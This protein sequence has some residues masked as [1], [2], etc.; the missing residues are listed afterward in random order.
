MASFSPGRGRIRRH[1]WISPFWTPPQGKMAAAR[2]MR[3][4]LS[5]LISE[6]S[7]KQK[8]YVQYVKHRK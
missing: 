1:D 2:E 6:N 4:L 3:A 7:S 8:F 5:H